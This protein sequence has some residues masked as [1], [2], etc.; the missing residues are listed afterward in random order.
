MNT[1]NWI[2]ELHNREPSNFDFFLK[3]ITSTY[4]YIESHESGNW[5]TS[6]QS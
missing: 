5:E 1:N 3:E 4:R 6:V 2:N